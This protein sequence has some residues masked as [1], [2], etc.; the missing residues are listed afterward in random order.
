MFAALLVWRLLSKSKGKGS[1]SDVRIP[2]IM[3][4]TKG[5]VVVLCRQNESLSDLMGRN[6][7]ESG[8]LTMCSP[9]D[10]T[11]ARGTVRKDASHVD[12]K[13]GDGKPGW[14]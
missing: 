14:F 10:E 11:V 3:E 5:C 9:K 13:G 7:R 2:S 12:K 8:S 4:N 6:R 1:V